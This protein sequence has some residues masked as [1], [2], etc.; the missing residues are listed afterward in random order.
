MLADLTVEYKFILKKENLKVG[1]V[2]RCV[3]NIVTYTKKH[4][5]GTKCWYRLKMA[6]PSFSPHIY[7][8]FDQKMLML[9]TE[10]NFLIF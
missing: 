7:A 8:T 4:L 6:K 10:M 1:N 9:P 2:T 5:W 3:C